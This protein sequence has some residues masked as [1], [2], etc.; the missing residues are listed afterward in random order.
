MSDFVKGFLLQPGRQ[1]FQ[2][3]YH[4]VMSVDNSPLNDWRIRM[5]DLTLL[6]LK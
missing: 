3:K 1:L 2:L 5:I 6:E 4:N